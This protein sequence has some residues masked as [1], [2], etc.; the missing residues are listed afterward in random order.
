MAFKILHTFQVKTKIHKKIL[1]ITLNKNYRMYPYRKCRVENLCGHLNNVV[2]KREIQKA[3]VPTKTCMGHQEDLYSIYGNATIMRNTTERLFFKGCSNV[4]SIHAMASDIGVDQA[5]PVIHMAVISGCMGSLLDIRPAGLMEHIL[6]KIGISTYRQADTTNA[7][8][9]SRGLSQGKA[10]YTSSS[11][12]RL[13][14]VHKRQCHY[15]PY[16]GFA[17]V[18]SRNRGKDCRLLQSIPQ[19]VQV[20]SGQYQNN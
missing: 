1:L 18:E 15:P 19:H 10:G 17:L 3:L 13:V 5:Q 8:C 4:K 20:S 11:T 6:H 14:H 7:L 16:V 12:E 9:F 2:N